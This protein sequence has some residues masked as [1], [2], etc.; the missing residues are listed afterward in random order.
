MAYSLVRLRKSG[1]G[2]V[3]LT[4]ALL[5]T[6]S[7]RQT[8]DYFRLYHDLRGER[9]LCEELDDEGY[10]VGPAKGLVGGS[11]KGSMRGSK[12]IQ[13]ELLWEVLDLVVRRAFHYV[14]EF[15]NWYRFGTEGS[16]EAS[17][18]FR[19]SGSFV[20]RLSV[21][22]TDLVSFGYTMVFGPSYT[23]SSMASYLAADHSLW[24]KLDVVFWS[25]YQHERKSHEVDVQG[26]VKVFSHVNLNEYIRVALSEGLLIAGKEGM[27]CVFKLC[28]DG[29][30]VTPPNKVPSDL[31]SGDV[32]VLNI[33]S[34][35]HKERPLRVQKLK[36]GSL[37]KFNNGIKDNI[38]KIWKTGSGN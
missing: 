8:K 4:E 30:F 11:V 2:C 10:H 26:C 34:T 36:C 20:D 25:G 35:K 3:G 16:I 15:G 28:M 22:V 23:Y 17:R 6:L 31:V 9:N 18:S 37:N 14:E 13:W 29:L 38:D 27:V 33:S 32:T 24:E 19:T 5:V 1:E 21:S 12:E 7:W